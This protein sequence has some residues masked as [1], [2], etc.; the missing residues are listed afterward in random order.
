MNI[1]SKF[2]VYVLVSCSIAILKM[3]KLCLLKSSRECRVLTQENLPPHDS[4]LKRTILK[5]AA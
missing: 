5:L 1:K 3:V 4:Q 2:P